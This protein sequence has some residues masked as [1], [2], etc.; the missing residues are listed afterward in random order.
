ML[1]VFTPQAR[2]GEVRTFSKSGISLNANGAYGYKHGAMKVSQYFTST[3]NDDEQRWEV[4]PTGNGNNILR[5]IAHN[6][7]LNSYQ[8]AIGTTPNLFPCDTNDTDQQVRIN[9]DAITHTATGLELNIG[10]RND[11]PVVWKKAGSG[12]TVQGGNEG[13]I[14]FWGFVVG[15]A[16][17]LVVEKAL[18]PNKQKWISFEEDHETWEE[19]NKRCV[20][21]AGYLQWTINKRDGIEYSEKTCFEK[22]L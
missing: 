5:N 20:K 16:A 17:T 2:A 13:S 8:T 18:T 15:G 12:V 10:D 9:G 19:V 22:D 6:K 3:Y 1:N 7:C 4:I 14:G 11:T 21:E